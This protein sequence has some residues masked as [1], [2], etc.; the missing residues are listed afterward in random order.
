[1]TNSKPTIDE[2]LAPSATAPEAAPAAHIEFD[3]PSA[4]A[5]IEQAIAAPV[6]ASKAPSEEPI[7][8]AA[9]FTANWSTDLFSYWNETAAAY[10]EYAKALAKVKTPAE[11]ISLQTKFASERYN[12]FMKRTQSLSGSPKSFLFMA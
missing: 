10:L 4:E 12:A 11:L 2:T 8:A 6:V 9:A 7:V 5:K 3:D 1:M